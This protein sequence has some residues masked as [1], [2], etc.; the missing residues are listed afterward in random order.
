LRFSG[1]EVWV[2]LF[3]SI[4]LIIQKIKIGLGF[5]GRTKI[6]TNRGVANGKIRIF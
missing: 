2:S 5:E 4:F 3:F 1:V 6:R